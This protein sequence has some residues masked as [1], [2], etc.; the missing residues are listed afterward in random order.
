M[1]RVKQLSLRYSG[2]FGDGR[3]GQGRA[4][5]ESRCDESGVV[6]LRYGE[7]PCVCAY[8]A[9]SGKIVV[10]CVKCGCKYVVD[11]DH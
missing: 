7:Q 5:Q 8:I 4:G 10:G 11:L 6:C 3:A 2:K 1:G 9:W